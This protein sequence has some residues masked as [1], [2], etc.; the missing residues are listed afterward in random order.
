MSNTEMLDVEFLKRR[1]EVNYFFSCLETMYSFFDQKQSMILKKK[2]DSPTLRTSD[3]M[4]ILKS[5]SFLMLYN[6][7]ESTV[8]SF[9][10]KIYDEITI[11]N[12]GYNDIRQELQKIWID[13]SYDQLGHTTTNFDQHKKKAK[14]MIG[15]VI[16][17]EKISLTE[18]DINL[19][20]NVDYRLIIELFKN[21]GLQMPTSHGASVGEGLR[22]IKRKRNTIAHGNVSFIDSA[23]DTSLS[24]LNVYKEDIIEYLELLNQSV[25][26]YIVNQNYKCASE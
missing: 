9:I 24:D 1:D 13:V 25:S 11:Q 20:G 26:D 22:E 7:I 16:S 23:R 19:S 10:Q 6:L 5:N 4:V 12:L 15:F 2:L 17:G 8:R 21:H 18:K 14:E 3:F